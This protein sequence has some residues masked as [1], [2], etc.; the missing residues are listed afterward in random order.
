MSWLAVGGL[1]VGTA[2]SAGGAYMSSKKQEEAAEKNAA[3]SGPENLRYA[4]PTLL[5]DPSQ[6]N[7]IDILRQMYDANWQNR[8]QGRDQAR[9]TNKFNTKE[10]LKAYEKMQPFFAE[11]QS[12]IGSNASSFMRGEIPQDA[13][14]NITRMTAQRGI[15]A[16]MGYGTGGASTGAFANLNARNLGLTSLE[17]A[18]YGTNLGMQANMQA[19]QLAPNLMGL[20]DFLMNPAQAI[21]INQFNAGAQ[22]Q[23]AM[24]NNQ[25]QNQF[26]LQNTSAY[27][28]AFQNQN[29][30]QYAADLMG[31]QMYGQMG[32]AIG[33][34]ISGFAGGLGTG[35]TGTSASSTAGWG[36]NYG[37]VAQGV[38]PRPATYNGTT[39]PRAQLA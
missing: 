39:I 26:E 3:A 21:G 24:A 20:Q 15:Q 1:V 23:F 14:D 37:P 18:K 29:Q 34:G 19:K 11:N 2:V 27:N 7:P 4:N 30:Q 5:G 12:L 10:A 36:G 17:L 8:Q 35:S 28:Q 16:G 32:Q 31:A 9:I 22:N 25:T 33:G 38:T 6:L 13:Q